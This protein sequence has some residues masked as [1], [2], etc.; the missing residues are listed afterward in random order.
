M[1]QLNL[2][3]FGAIMMGFW[4]ASA[5]FFKFWSDTRDRLFLIFGIAFG[6]MAI[7]RLVLGLITTTGE[8]R[9]YYFRIVAFGLILMGIYDKN[10]NEKNDRR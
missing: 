2:F 5:F 8:H 3:L 10:R 1:S 7:E 4:I 9:V 6:I